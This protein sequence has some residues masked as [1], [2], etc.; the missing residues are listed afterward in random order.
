MIPAILTAAMPVIGEVIDRLFPDSEKRELAR[1]EIQS[2][3]QDSL[4][5][6]DLA[7]MEVNKEEA[8]SASLFVAGWRPFIGWTC[9]VAFAYH[10]IVQ[11]FLVFVM[12]LAGK[13]VT[14]PV[15][16]MDALF[17]VL[18]GMLGLGAMRSVEKVKGVTMGLSGVLPWA[19]KK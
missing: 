1:L 16:D 8:K 4:N 11:P 6:L 15:F 5:Q 7:Q 12:S 18:M 3:L 17:T 14:L 10:F 13:T 9:G 2:K 19:G